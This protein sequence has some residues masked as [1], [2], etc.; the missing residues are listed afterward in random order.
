MSDSRLSVSNALNAV[1][2]VDPIYQGWGCGA[3][4][5]PDV[6]VPASNH[7]D[8]MQVRRDVARCLSMPM[9]PHGRDFRVGMDVTLDGRNVHLMGVSLFNCF[10]PTIIDFRSCRRVMHELGRPM[11]AATTVGHAGFGKCVSVHAVNDV[12]RG[13]QLT[14]PVSLRTEDA[15][16]MVGEKGATLAV[17]TPKRAELYCFGTM[18]EDVMRMRRNEPVY[19]SLRKRVVSQS[20]TRLVMAGLAAAALLG[21]MM[22]GRRSPAG[23]KRL[24]PQ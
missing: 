1:K 11:P 9:R 22:L 10:A 13:P 3:R 7:A 20:P 12:Y 24:L 8:Y 23:G 15:G 14:L 2:P 17:I 21:A 18:S 5:A 19:E 4:R 6:V 16:L